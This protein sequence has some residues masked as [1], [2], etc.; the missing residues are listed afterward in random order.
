[1]FI[2][3]GE[4]TGNQIQITTPK[5]VE[6]LLGYTNCLSMTLLTPPNIPDD[7]DKYF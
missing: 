1:M 2:A 4:T 5:R 6:C 3:G 7:L